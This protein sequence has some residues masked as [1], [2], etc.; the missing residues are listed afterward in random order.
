MDIAIVGGGIGGL[1]A[2]LALQDR[3]F[4]PTIYESA[5]DM[6][7]LGVGI[8]LLPHAVR[9][10]D[11][12]GLRERLLESGIATAE[13]LYFNKFGQRI[14]REPRGLE[15]G[16]AW[17]QVSIHRGRLHGLLHAE[18]IARLG[19]ERVVHGHHL[20]A[21]DTSA[22]HPLLHFTERSSGQSRASVA[23]DVA[24]GADGI[25][26]RVRRHFYPDE[27][28]PIWNGA[29]LW[30]AMTEGAP[31]LTG[32]SMFM[33]GHANQKFVCYPI[34]RAHLDRGSSLINWVAELR[35]DP[36]RPFAREDWNRKV[37]RETFLP[38]FRDWRF[39]W[40]DIPALIEGAAEVFEYPMVDRDPVARWSFGRVSLLGDAAHPMYPVGSNGASQAILD[41]EALA[42]ALATTP[43][44]A[45]AL[46]AYEAVRLEPTA[47][48][49]RA[50][51]NQGPE[52]VMQLVEERAPQGFANLD[53]VVSPDE[54]EGIAARYKQIA[55]FDRKTLNSLAGGGRG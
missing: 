40:L 22:E 21:L 25:H 24:I 6:R 27:G 32:R 16:Y 36:D 55:G 33:A 38:A 5:A 12:L 17:P 49:V 37:D 15:A 31:F 30:R 4:T 1:V 14:W 46:A 45:A 18:A 7:E 35:F 47:A 43:G 20:A 52:Q 34:S 8:N 3:G 54:L 44:P 10:L 2:A 53:D 41:A 42:Q 23:C 48:I 50:N 28:P 29:I 11:A 51:R 39:D 13:L 9:V 26:S 19:P